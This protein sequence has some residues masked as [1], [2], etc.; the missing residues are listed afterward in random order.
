METKEKTLKKLSKLSQVL[1]YLP[2][3]T[4]HK[5]PSPKSHKKYPIEN[6]PTDFSQSS[7]AI[8]NPAPLHKHQAVDLHTKAEITPL[9]EFHQREHNRRL[10]MLASH[11]IQ[12]SKL[13][14]LSQVTSNPS[15]ISLHLT[16]APTSTPLT[17]RQLI[18]LSFCTRD[19][20]PMVLLPPESTPQTQRH[21]RDPFPTVISIQ[22]TMSIRSTIRCH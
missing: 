11:K 15:L 9:Q 20:L 17:Q 4:S 1:P 10:P 5:I 14:T 18:Y 12:H 16:T 19:Q 7:S 3:S 21:N 22:A 8:I 6:T 13:P 2:S